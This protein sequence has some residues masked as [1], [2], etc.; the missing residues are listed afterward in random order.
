MV[1]FVLS[2]V[3]GCLKI[4]RI[5]SLTMASRNC[6]ELSPNN[7]TNWKQCVIA[8][9]TS[10]GLDPIQS[11]ILTCKKISFYKIITNPSEFYFMGL[12]GLFLSSSV[13]LFLICIYIFYVCV[14]VP[15]IK[16]ITFG[17]WPDFKNWVFLFSYCIL[18]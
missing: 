7:P 17:G 11:L 9:K 16:T 6:V 1:N 12:A 4:Y 5:S 10:I 2:T 15:P 3:T 8:P 18:P 13:Y 14:Q